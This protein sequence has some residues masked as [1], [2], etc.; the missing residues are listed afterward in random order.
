MLS[1]SASSSAASSRS[2][3]TSRALRRPVVGLITDAPPSGPGPARAGPGLPARRRTQR[4]HVRR[5][6]PGLII[7]T[8]AVQFRGAAGQPDP[9]RAAE[10]PVAALVFLPFLVFTLAYYLISLCVNFSHPRLRPG[11]PPALVDSWRP[12]RYPSLDIFLPICGEHPDVLAI[13]GPMSRSSSRP[14]PVTVVRLRARRRRQTKRRGGR[15]GSSGS[16]YVVRPDRGWIKKAGNLRHAF[17]ISSGEFIAILDAD[18]APR[19]DLPAEMLPY[20]YADPSSASCSRRSTSARTGASR[21]WSAAPARCRNCSTGS[22]RSRGTATTARSA[23]APAPFTAAKRLAANGGSYPDRA[24]R[25][26]AHRL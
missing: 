22:C 4:R 11:A 24:F 13:P 14:I 23:S 15:R 3:R 18:F 8:L 5:P 10:R 19:A 25:G 17:G 1:P 7:R 20:F 26:R 2:G 6:E 12:A 21:G 16:P 9:V